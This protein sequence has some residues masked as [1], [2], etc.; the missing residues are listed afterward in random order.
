V[1]SPR[2]DPVVEKATF[3]TVTVVE[4]RPAHDVDEHKPTAVAVTKSRPAHVY[5]R[6][7]KEFRPAHGDEQPPSKHEGKRFKQ[8]Y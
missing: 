7:H 2:K 1:I 6:G 8:L 4:S 5:D 3:T